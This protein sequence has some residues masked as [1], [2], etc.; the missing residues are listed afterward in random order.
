MS[1]IF[2]LW[3]QLISRQLRLK[4][5]QV[6]GY[7]PLVPVVA[8]ADEVDDRRSERGIGDGAEVIARHDRDVAPAIFAASGSGDPT[9]S[10][11]SPTRISVG[12]ADRITRNGLSPRVC[13]EHRGEG[14]PE[15]GAGRLGEGTER[16]RNRVRDARCVVRD[17]SVRER[18]AL[19]DRTARHR[20]A[21]DTPQDEAARPRFHGHES[22][23][24]E[25]PHRVADDIELPERMRPPIS[26]ED[27]ER[28]RRPP[29]ARP[30]LIDTSSSFAGCR[31][32][33]LAGQ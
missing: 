30:S 26:F 5:A 22:R 18:T 31:V 12:P 11:R 17:E 28:C 2:G 6:G 4:P 33:W 19:R 27:V 10:S 1:R 25:R 23:G 20:S 15:V 14:M 13:A 8:S 7:A 16:S 21:T 29:F 9:R 3:R 24:D 32:T